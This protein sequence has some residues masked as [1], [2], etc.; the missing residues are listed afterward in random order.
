VFIGEV[1]RER[2][3]FG[4]RFPTGPF[5]L[6]RDE[7]WRTGPAPQDRHAVTAPTLPPLRHY[8]YPRVAVKGR[9]A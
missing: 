9:S 5:Q 7:T 1:V 2:R 8:G 3:G 4:V 6:R